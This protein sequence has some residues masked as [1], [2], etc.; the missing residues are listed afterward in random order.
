MTVVSVR[1]FCAAFLILL[2]WA[3]RAP[4]QTASPWLPADHWSVAAVGRLDALG[5]LPPFDATA[6]QHTSVRVAMLLR[7]A[8]RAAVALGPGSDAALRLAEGYER[9][10]AEE[11]PHAFARAVSAEGAYLATSVASG[12]V[13]RENA[14]LAGGYTPDRD[15]TGPRPLRDTRSAGGAVHAGGAA[16]RHIA[17]TVSATGAG[18]V[19]RV[20]QLALDVTAGPA[21]VWIGRRAPGYSPSRGGGLVLDGAVAFEGS[22]V[23]TL[24]PL[25]VPIL[26]GLEGELFGGRVDRNGFVDRPWFMAMRAHVSPH[27]RLSVGATRAAVFGG[28]NGSSVGPRQLA[29]VLVGANLAGDYADDQVA[30]IDARWRL[31]TRLPLQLYAEWGMHDADPGV[32]FVMP[33]FSVGAWLPALPFAPALAVGIEHTRIARSCCNNPPWYR[34]FELAEGWTEGGVPIGHPLGGH[35]HEWRARISGAPLDA[36]LLLDASII[37]RN[38]GEENLY[39]PERG[40]DAAG[41]EATL[42]ARITGWLSLDAAM[43]IEDGTGWRETH[44]AARLRAHF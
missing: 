18:A 35:G 25:R 26:G 7:E 34:H 8:V 19:W 23:Y 31:P 2:M 15:W 28:M 20:T 42:D 30:S 12:L 33:S 4:A 22:G 1:S 40:G 44:A 21:G 38:R 6:R 16:G 29:E 3:T 5:L 27:A 17:A 36:R 32:L 39:A 9:R 11:W 41:V 10:F 43:R 14:R 37:L 13:V 24:R